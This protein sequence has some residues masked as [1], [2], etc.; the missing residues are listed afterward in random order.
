MLAELPCKDSRRPWLSLTS[1]VHS[2]FQQRGLQCSH[3]YFVQW[4]RDSEK[5]CLALDQRYFPCLNF[6]GIVKDQTDL[7]LNLSYWSWLGGL[8]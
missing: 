1:E 5:L 8:G 4:S 3:Q 7:D 2:T 6:K